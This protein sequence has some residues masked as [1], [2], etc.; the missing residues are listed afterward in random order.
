MI[1]FIKVKGIKEGFFYFHVSVAVFMFIFK[2]YIMNTFY[3]KRFY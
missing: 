2:S 3:V 1:F